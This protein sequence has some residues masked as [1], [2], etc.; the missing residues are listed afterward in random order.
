MT[1]RFSPKIGTKASVYAFT[2]VTQRSSGSSSWYNKA[3]KE[4][5][6]GREKEK[7]AFPCRQDAC[8]SRKP[9]EPTKKSPKPAK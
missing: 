7:P 5:A 8:L 1:V 9:K 4:N 6:F 3:R 2:A